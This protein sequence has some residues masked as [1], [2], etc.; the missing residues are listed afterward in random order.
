MALSLLQ[1]GLQYQIASVS[2]DHPKEV[3]TLLIRGSMILDLLEK[4]AQKK[5]ASMKMCDPIEVYLAYPVK[6]QK[7]LK[8]P[9]DVRGMRYFSG[10][11]EED[12]LIARG[13]VEQALVDKEGL[14]QDLIQRDVWIQTLTHM[15]PKEVGSLNQARE[16]ALN[17]EHC[18]YPSMEEAYRRGL[19]KL[20]RK[21]LDGWTP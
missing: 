7:A 15:D 14:Y 9:I 18:D 11:K 19:L 3:A 20:T 13:E 8:I 21:A 5:V 4:I 16:E 6:L 1:L 17:Q 12:F 10:L 2:K